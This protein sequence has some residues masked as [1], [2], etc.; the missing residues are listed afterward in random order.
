M[1]HSAAGWSYVC[2]NVATRCFEILHVFSLV[3]EVWASCEGQNFRL[4]PLLGIQAPKYSLLK[5]LIKQFKKGGNWNGLFLSLSSTGSAV[6]AKLKKDSLLHVHACKSYCLWNEAA[7]F[8]TWRLSLLS[9]CNVTSCE[10]N[11]QTF[12]CRKGFHI[13]SMRTDMKIV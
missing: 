1:F 2:N 10:P 7:E 3:F 6:G 12:S 11:P 4:L 8:P 5:N 9:S 13:L